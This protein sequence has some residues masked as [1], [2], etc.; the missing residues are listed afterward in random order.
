MAPGPRGGEAA[1]PPVGTP[2]WEHFEHK[3][4]IGVRGIGRTLSESFEQAALALTAVAVDPVTIRTPETVRVECQSDDPEMLLV[5]WLNA[6]IFEAATRRMLFGRYAVEIRDGHLSAR[7]YGE[8]I[9]RDRHQPA[10]EA[11]GATF[12][13]LHV[14]QQPDGTWI[15]QCVV[16]V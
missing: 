5:D 12:T 11:K 9:D 2:R 15:A 6:I 4:D 7:L 14:A 8:P 16:D 1:D 3:A 10:V 13:E